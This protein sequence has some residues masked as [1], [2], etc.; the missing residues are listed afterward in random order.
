VD[1][2]NARDFDDALHV[3]RL[4]SGDIE[5]GIHIADVAQVVEEGSPEDE[6]ARKVGTSVYLAHKAVHMLPER[7]SKELCALNPGQKRF[8]ISVLL[9]LNQ[10]GSVASRSIHEG[11]VCSRRRLTYSDVARICV[12]K[13]SD[14]R[15]KMGEFTQCLDLA[16]ELSEKIR[17]KWA[18]R[19]RFD[20]GTNET[21]LTLDADQLIEDVADWAPHLGHRMIETFMV[22]ANETVAKEMIKREI[23]IPF[24]NHE[25]PKTESLKALALRL[26]SCGFD[27]SPQLPKQ[28]W[29]LFHRAAGE[30]SDFEGSTLRFWQIQLVSALKMATYGANNMGHFGLHTRAYTHFTSPIRRYADL[31]V[32]RR[33]KRILRDPDLGPEYFNDADLD[34]LCRHLTH[35]ER[36]CVA[37]QTLFASMK[38][39]RHLMG[40]VGSMIDGTISGV[41]PS[42]LFVLLDPWCYEAVVSVRNLEEDGFYF[43]SQGSGYLHHRKKTSVGLGTRVHVRISSV[44]L[45]SRTCQLNLIRI[46]A[47]SDERA[48]KPPGKTGESPYK[49]KKI[50]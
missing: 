32:H 3:R 19:G 14:A 25:F 17:Q 48:Q 27:V 30:I 39:L 36:A 4:D 44:D 9:R 8:S 29:R 43:D 1:D 10:D 28:P 20:L 5:V 15:D 2:E 34:E 46:H 42:G 45:V 11:I 13:D 23:S 18:N 50:H 31:V 38:L 6:W 26:S 33:L 16:M 35:R 21:R 22:L 24:R 12:E 47:N 7:F 49:P 37:A 40:R 41:A